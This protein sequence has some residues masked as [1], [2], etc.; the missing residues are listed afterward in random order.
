MKISHLAAPDMLNEIR[1]MK[2]MYYEL[3]CSTHQKSAAVW[4]QQCGLKSSISGVACLV[5]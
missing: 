5:N 1:I 3:I 2:L 4:K